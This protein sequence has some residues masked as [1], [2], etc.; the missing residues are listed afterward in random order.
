MR[1]NSR[2]YLSEGLKVWSDV[3]RLLEVFPCFVNSAM[4]LGM[5]AL[6]KPSSSAVLVTEALPY[7]LQQFALFQ[8]LL[9]HVF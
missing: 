7:E 4:V 5:A 2:R 1:F 6:G 3:L 9:G 8:T